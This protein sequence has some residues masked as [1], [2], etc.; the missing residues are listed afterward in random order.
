MQSNQGTLAIYEDELEALRDAVR[1]LGGTKTV[2]HDLRSDLAPDQ[3]G[4][5][6]K[7]CLNADRR[8]KLSLSQTMLVLRKARDAGYHGPMQ[9]ISGE[10]GYAVQPIEPADEAAELQRQFI[11]AV[12][13]QKSLIDRIER[14]T[15]APISAVKSA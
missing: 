10:I 11:A 15:R 1:A 3:A 8:E 9:Y 2:G 4:H 6:L 12:G 7:D 13:A 5:W 14:L